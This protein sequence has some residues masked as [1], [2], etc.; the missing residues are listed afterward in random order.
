MILDNVTLCNNTA[1]RLG[2]VLA[3]HAHRRAHL[4]PFLHAAGRYIFDAGPHD[5]LGR[6]GLRFGFN[7][8]VAPRGP[9]LAAARVRVECAG[10]RA[11]GG[12][13]GSMDGLFDGSSRVVGCRRQYGWDVRTSGD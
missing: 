1:S 13:V 9:A 8:P 12:S 11:A 6:P 2:S 3:G 5:Y 4:V 10:R 7:R